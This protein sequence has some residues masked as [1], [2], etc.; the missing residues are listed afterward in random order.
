MM[1][2]N[3]RTNAD[4]I[5]SL[6]ELFSIS[7][8]ELEMF[9]IDLKRRKQMNYQFNEDIIDNLIDSYVL[10]KTQRKLVIDEVLFLSLIHI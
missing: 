2:I 5:K 3:T 1:H 10:E 8:F 9:L 4:I 7:K 6:E